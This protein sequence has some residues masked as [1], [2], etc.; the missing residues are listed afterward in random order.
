MSDQPDKMSIDKLTPHPKN[1]EIYDPPS[2]EEIK[3]LRDSILEHGMLSPIVVTGTGK[4]ISG[5]RRLLAAKAAKLPEVEVSW[6]LYGSEDLEVE[7]LISANMQRH[8]SPMEMHREAQAL[9]AVLDRRGVKGRTSDHLA[10]RVGMNSGRQ[11]ERIDYVLEHAPEIIKKQLEE[12]KITVSSAYEQTKDLRK[13][14]ENMQPAIVN[15]LVQGEAKTVGEAARV[16]KNETNSKLVYKAPK[17][18]ELGKYGTILVYPNWDFSDLGYTNAGPEEWGKKTSRL[19]DA[20]TL[21]DYSY[22]GKR[23]PDLMAEI[24]DLYLLAPPIILD[25]AIDVLRN[26]GFLISGVMTWVSDKPLIPWLPV[27]FQM[28]TMCSILGTTAEEFQRSKQKDWF[29]G[30]VTDHGFIPDTFYHLIEKNSPGPYLQIFAQSER[31]SWT[32]I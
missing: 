19:V 26:W 25:Q 23:I 11:L 12:E 27:K 9:K 17:G 31:P 8:K 29:Y 30:D 1:A 14:P 22:E 2:V 10:A 24:C 20:V 4:V 32:R 7:A 13:Q 5:H 28:S 15:K 21:A 6:K 16:V 18:A 3:A